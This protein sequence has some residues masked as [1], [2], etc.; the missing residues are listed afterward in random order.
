MPPS[1]SVTKT[2]LFTAKFCLQ[3]V[4]SALVLDPLSAVAVYFPGKNPIL[5]PSKFWPQTLLVKQG[6]LRWLQIAVRLKI[7]SPAPLVLTR[8]PASRDLKTG[9]WIANPNQTE[10]KTFLTHWVKTISVKT[11][12]G[13][14]CLKPEKIALIF[15]SECKSTYHWVWNNFVHELSELA[16]GCTSLIQT[17]WNK[18]S[19]DK[20]WSKVITASF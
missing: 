1:S 3:F 8:P 4:F 20:L 6:I 12:S 2:S 16:R 18:V 17:W 11:F 7:W 19:V 5:T 14:V 10:S 9:Y 15:N 13:L